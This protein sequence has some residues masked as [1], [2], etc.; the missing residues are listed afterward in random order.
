MRAAKGLPS[1]RALASLHIRTSRR[2]LFTT[3]GNDE[4]MDLCGGVFDEILSFIAYAQ[5]IFYMH[6]QLS[7]RI[8]ARLSGGMHA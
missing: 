5:S 7:C 4:I 3:D 2:C 6:V 8:H 1:L